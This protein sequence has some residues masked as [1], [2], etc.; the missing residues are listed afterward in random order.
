M[1]LERERVRTT[2]IT[3]PVHFVY[4]TIVG[5]IGAVA[6]AIG[7]W[8][9]YAPTAGTLSLFGW[10]WD[11]ANLAEGWPLSLM[12]G[13]GLL[14]FGAFAVA[15]QKMYTRDGELT[16][17]SVANGLLALAALAGAV[18]YALIWIF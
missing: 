7:A 14:L 4:E 1:T 6:G 3:T 12:I 18:T 5:V 15:A 8:M 11:V 13:G 9:Y 17:G 16:A 2:A 10:E